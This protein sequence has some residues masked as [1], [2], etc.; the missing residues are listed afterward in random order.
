[1]RRYLH[2][3]VTVNELSDVLHSLS[4]KIAATLYVYH[5]FLGVFVDGWKCPPQDYP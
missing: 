1:M 2:L 4:L 5:M 3:Y